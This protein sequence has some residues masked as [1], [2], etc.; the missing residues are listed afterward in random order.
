MEMPQTLWGPR[1]EGDKCPTLPSFLEERTPELGTGARA[2]GGTESLGEGTVRAAGLGV[3]G[4]QL[5]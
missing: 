4:G 2:S 5:G 3:R 1:A